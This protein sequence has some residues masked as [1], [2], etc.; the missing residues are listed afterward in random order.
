MDE[1]PLGKKK[2][3]TA[4]NHPMTRAAIMDEFPLGLKQAGRIL[5]L[6]ANCVK[7][8]QLTSHAGISKISTDR[9][10]FAGY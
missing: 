5:T 10:G 9:R 2:A 6:P 4:F 8:M 1:F 3:N 7:A